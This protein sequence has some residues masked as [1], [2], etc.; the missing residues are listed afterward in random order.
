MGFCPTG[1][2]EVR[3]RDGLMEIEMERGVVHPLRSGKI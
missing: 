3:E 1:Q 2:S